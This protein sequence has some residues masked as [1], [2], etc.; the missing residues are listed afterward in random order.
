MKKIGVDSK[1]P[2]LLYIATDIVL[3]QTHDTYSIL[4]LFNNIVT[5]TD[6]IDGLQV[7][8]KNTPGPY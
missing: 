8:I 6:R 5:A 3:R 1:R 2:V 4:E 7:V